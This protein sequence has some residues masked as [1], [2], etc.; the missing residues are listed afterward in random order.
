MGKAWCVA[1]VLALTGGPALAADP[2]GNWLVADN[3]A[4]VRI[5]PCADAYCGTIAWTSQPGTDEHNP[6]PSR[7][8]RPIVGTQILLGMKP[9]GGNRWDGEIY[10]PENGKTY[11]GHIVLL[12][13]DRLRIEGCLLFF[14]GGET[15]TRAR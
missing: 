12:S 2:G 3:T 13:P 7:R 15:W 11:S 10:N 1:A 14:C 9:A 5:A 6:D 4:V 8:D